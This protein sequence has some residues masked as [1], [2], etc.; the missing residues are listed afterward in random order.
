MN[1]DGSSSKLHSEAEPNDGPSF[2]FISS[3]AVISLFCF[4]K[5]TQTKQT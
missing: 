1:T 2:Q 3:L 5:Q 4:L